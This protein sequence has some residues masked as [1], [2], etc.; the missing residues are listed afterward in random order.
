MKRCLAALRAVL[1]LL[2]GC[3]SELDGGAAA[4]KGS[5]A[6]S[7]HGVNYSGDPF[8][9]GVTH[10]NASEDTGVGEHIGP[11]SA[12]GT[13]CCFNLPEK[14]KPGIKLTVYASHWVGKGANNGADTVDKVHTVE[15]PPY[16][17]GKAGELWVMRTAEGG[18]EVV[19]SDLQPDHP[20]WPGKVKGWP[21]P[22]LEFQRKHWALL[23]G[24]AIQAVEDNI[25]LLEELKRTPHAAITKSWKFDRQYRHD[26]IANFS[27]PE[28]PRY[29][30]YLENRY[31]E[32]LQQSKARV[33]ESLSEKP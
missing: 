16:A 10:P 17:D 13:V 12:G 20:Q 5:V 9:F 32:G 19:S 21:E 26:E 6:V 30:D 23:H 33:A 29:A 22:S 7:V 31:K 4:P 11:F 27:G 8:K 14:W 15:L 18:L 24:Y 28:D 25:S 2:A 1:I 3:T